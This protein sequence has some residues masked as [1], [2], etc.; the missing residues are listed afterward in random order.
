MRLRTEAKLISIYK[1][2]FKDISQ[3]IIDSA[4][5][6]EIKL[7]SKLR[8]RLAEAIRYKNLKPSLAFFQGCIYR[9]RYDL[10][11]AAMAA[12]IDLKNDEN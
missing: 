1:E 6:H 8:I 2:L 4:L 3:Y 7:L 11:N 5:P 12:Y 10:L 9:E